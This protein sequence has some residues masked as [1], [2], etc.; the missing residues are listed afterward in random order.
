M[1]HGITIDYENNIWVTDVALHQVMKFKKGNNTPLMVLG[2]AFLPGKIDKFCK[3]T[4]VAVL[5]NGDFFVADGY[6]NARIIK[7][8]KNGEIIL[9]WGR[10]IFQGEQLGLAPENY[11][12]IPHALTLALDLGLVCVA[13][14]ENGRVQC[15][16]VTT[17]TFHSQYHSPLI[18]DRLFSVA[19]H[20]GNGGRLYVVNGPDQ[21]KPPD[22]VMGFI[23]DM[24]TKK[25]ISKI[26]PINGSLGNPHDIIVSNDGI[27]VIIVLR[28]YA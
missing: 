22:R 15:F 28:F 16:N 1:P 23:I 7:Y 25:V 26:S 9:E 20:A 5:P 27:E 17:G 10:N 12:A 3:P 6:C 24:Q 13:D 4:A 8:S 2:K 14:R 18:G 19:Y 21:F 11:F